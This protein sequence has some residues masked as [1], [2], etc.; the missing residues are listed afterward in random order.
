VQGVIHFFAADGNWWGPSRVVEGAINE[1]PAWS[2][3]LGDAHP[4]YLNLGFVPFAI[5]VGVGIVRSA[6]SRVEQIAEA[7]VGALVALAWVF[8]TNAWETPVVIGLLL[9]AAAVALLCR[10]FQPSQMP[11]SIDHQGRQR[12]LVLVAVAIPLVVS[13]A[14]SVQNIQ[15]PNMPLKFV[16]APVTR[17]PLNELMLH[18]GVPFG[19]I[20]I[21][22]V[23]VLSRWFV[24]GVVVLFVIAW[25]SQMSWLFILLLIG[26]GAAQLLK[27]I[28]L[29]PGEASSPVPFFQE[30]FWGVIGLSG[31]VFI[32]IPEFLYFDDSYGPEI[33]RMNTIFKFYSASWF[34]VHCYAFWLLSRVAAK[35]QLPQL[36]GTIIVFLIVMCGFF[37]RTVDLRK[38]KDP[39]IQPASQGLSELDRKY[40]GAGK[41]IQELE[42]L[43]RGAVLEAQGGAYSLT[44]HVATLSGNPSYLGWANHVGLLARNDEE[45]KELTRRQEVTTT[46]YNSTDC[47]ETASILEREQIRYLVLGPLERAAF[48]GITPDRYGC[49]QLATGNGEYLI[50]SNERRVG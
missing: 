18:W 15:S 6:K 20:A 21:G 23:A 26:L 9:S 48:P 5:L 31:L 14:L 13:L 49:L 12:L 41:T 38:S 25:T 24:I 39:S 35:F 29:R 2:F 45:R 44:T 30:L 37:L 33:D 46:L 11:W 7:L 36:R 19:M 43:P 42:R 27:T 17:T 40:S 8:N 32:L 3:L 16:A 47:N 10:A 34:M 4:H 50:F 28:R 22:L 1:F